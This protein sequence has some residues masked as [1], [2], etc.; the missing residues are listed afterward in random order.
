LEYISFDSTVPK[1]STANDTHRLIHSVRLCCSAEF[2]SLAL[3]KVD[4]LE[5]TVASSA[6]A[7]A[8]EGKGSGGSP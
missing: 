5:R 7:K 6:R 4:G 8:L 2:S 3:A 1:S